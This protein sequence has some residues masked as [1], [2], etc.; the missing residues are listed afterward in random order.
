[1]AM[2]IARTR[3]IRKGGLFINSRRNEFFFMKAGY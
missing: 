1:M 3:K 2:M